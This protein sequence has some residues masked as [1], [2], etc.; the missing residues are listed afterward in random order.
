M[1]TRLGDFSPIGQLFTLG[2]FLKIIKVAQNCGLNVCFSENYKSSPKCWA[3]FHSG[4]GYVL[5]LTGNGLAAFGAIFS[6][7]SP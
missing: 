4:K 2:G 7:W 6:P 1:V 5:I 3:K